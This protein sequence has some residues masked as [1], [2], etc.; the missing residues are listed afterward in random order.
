MYY[1]R[2]LELTL[3]HTEDGTETEPLTDIERD[4]WIVDGLEFG[5]LHGTEA[6]AY[7]EPGSTQELERAKAVIEHIM[8]M[9]DAE[10]ARVNGYINEQRQLRDEANARKRQAEIDQHARH[11]ALLREHR[12]YSDREFMAEEAVSR[13]DEASKLRH[14]IIGKPTEAFDEQ[15]LRELRQDKARAALDQAQ[16]QRVVTF[17][18]AGARSEADMLAGRA[19]LAIEGARMAVQGVAARLKIRGIGRTA[20]ITVG[21]PKERE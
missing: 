4:K 11:E 7:Y 17:G 13:Y 14:R 2:Y 19:P 5:P 1:K 15:V 18:S 20:E 3:G 10:V 21:Y 8:D 12:V 9:Y 16:Q 6:D